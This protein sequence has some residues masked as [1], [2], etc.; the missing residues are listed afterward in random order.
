MTEKTIIEINGVK[1]E[2]DLS[3]AKRVDEFRVGDNVKVLT[4]DYSTYKSH[5]GIIVGFDNFKN[6]PTIIVAYLS[7]EY[8]KAEV[9]FVYINSQSE[10]YEICHMNKDEKLLDKVTALDFLDREVTR[11][12]ATLNELK[13]KR[14][15]FIEKYGVIFEKDK[16][17]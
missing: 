13:L 17:S 15:F 5:L 6:L 9:K 11:A 16:L 8:S 14:E 7:I 2:I 1:L 12:E 10:G 3:S 4:K